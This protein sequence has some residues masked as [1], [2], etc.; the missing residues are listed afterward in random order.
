MKLKIIVIALL[1]LLYSVAYAVENCVD[2]HSHPELTWDDFQGEVAEDS[3]YAA[4]SYWYIYYRWEGNKVRA[5]SCFQTSKAWIRDGKQSDY[6]LK[7]EQLHFDIAQLH[8]RLFQKKLESVTTT[9]QVKKLFDESLRAAKQMQVQYDEETQHSRNKPEQKR[10][11]QW[12]ADQLEQLDDYGFHRL[13]AISERNT[14]KTPRPPV[15]G[16]DVSGVWDSDYGTL[17]LKQR[18]QEVTGTYEYLED[19]DTK[20]RGTVR[21]TLNKRTLN[22]T[23]Y[24]AEDSGEMQLRFS[25]DGL[26]FRGEWQ[27]EDGSGEWNG[28]RQ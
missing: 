5:E 9:A 20:V 10:W 4:M 11:N 23:W 14:P 19:D 22:G 26:S 16:F 21:G 12:V 15:K 13:I 7:H 6:L 3:Q 24:E 25:E 27:E 8:I 1:S 28:E 18:G 2:W 17:T